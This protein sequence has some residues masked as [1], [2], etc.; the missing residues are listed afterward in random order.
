MDSIVA[1]GAKKVDQ[2]VA[3][4][5]GSL[6][7]AASQAVGGATTTASQIGDAFNNKKDE[8]SRILQVRTILVLL[9]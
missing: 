6:S 4:S 5:N 8:A 3:G 2:Q 7:G 9:G 1:S